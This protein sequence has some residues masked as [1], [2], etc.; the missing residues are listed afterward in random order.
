MRGDL[1]KDIRVV[2]IESLT[3]DGSPRLGGESNDHIRSLAAIEDELPPI[4]VHAETMRIIDGMHRIRAAQLKGATSIEAEFFS[5]TEEEAFVIAVKSNISHGL[6]LTL[7]DR[8]AA[9]ERLISLHPERS[10]RWLAATAGISAAIIASIRQSACLNSAPQDSRVGKDGKVRPLSSAEGRLAAQQAIMENPQASLR[11]IA[12]IS[13]VSPG[14][15][16]DVRR[17]MLSGE[18]PVPDATKQRRRTS[19]DAQNQPSAKSHE[20]LES[21]DTR[22]PGTDHPRFVAARMT[23]LLAKLRKD[24][25]IRQTET[26]RNL[27]RSL[28]AS[29]QALEYCMEQITNIPPHS[30]Y[31]IVEFTS[32]CSNEWT[33]LGGRLK[34]RL[35]LEST[36]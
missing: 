5:G 26:G 14:T 9:A 25:S 29:V 1:V 32:H 16:R 12:R 27:L 21:T 11:D 7:A 15:V 10:D 13:G 4:L 35:E 33:A 31:L 36:E 34:E 8:E 20:A 24:P 17:R 23:S 18:H 6:P 28:D 2:L 3:T 22:G 30:A 19:S